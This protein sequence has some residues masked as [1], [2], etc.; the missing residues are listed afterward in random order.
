[1][2][3]EPDLELQEETRKSPEPKRRKL[4][5]EKE[6]IELAVIGLEDSVNFLSEQNRRDLS[7][8]L[9]SIEFL[10]WRIQDIL[11]NLDDTI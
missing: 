10:N 3:I 6:N 7:P 5:E 4:S 9:E 11:V 8:F 1:M 2:W